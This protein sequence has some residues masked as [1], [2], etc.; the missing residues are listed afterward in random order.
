ML[1]IGEQPLLT[2]KTKAAQSITVGGF[3]VGC[4]RRLGLA[5]DGGGGQPC[6]C[7]FLPVHRQ[8]C[9][10]NSRFDQQAPIPTISLFDFYTI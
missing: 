4:W 9:A 8:C 1:N 6:G 3:V 2:K 7:G 10:L 5:S